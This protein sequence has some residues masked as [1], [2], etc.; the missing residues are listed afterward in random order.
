MKSVAPTCF[1]CNRGEYVT[2]PGACAAIQGEL[3]ASTQPDLVIVTLGGNEIGSKHLDVQ[4][5]GG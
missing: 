1:G 4:G 5:R 2:Q 3:V